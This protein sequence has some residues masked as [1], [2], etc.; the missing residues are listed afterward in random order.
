MEMLPPRPDAELPVERANSPLEKLPRPLP[1]CTDPLAPRALMPL[2]KAT[3]PLSPATVWPLEMLTSPLGDDA[4]T[5]VPVCSVRVPEEALAP[6]CVA[7]SMEPPEAVELV[8][9]LAPL[10]ICTLPPLLVA[11]LPLFI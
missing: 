1:I 10:M 11:L 5:T 6:L 3:R 2:V 8:E 7:M 4:E 9:E